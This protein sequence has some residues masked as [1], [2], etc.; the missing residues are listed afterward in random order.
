MDWTPTGR[1]VFL[2]FAGSVPKKQDSDL[3]YYYGR[4]I[5]IIGLPDMQSRDLRQI[6]G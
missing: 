6:D 3:L 5:N 4:F 1:L 2:R